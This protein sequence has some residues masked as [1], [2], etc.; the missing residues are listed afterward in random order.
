MADL[1]YEYKELGL[2]DLI[3]NAVTAG[4]NAINVVVQLFRSRGGGILC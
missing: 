2:F 4:S 3:H 1:D